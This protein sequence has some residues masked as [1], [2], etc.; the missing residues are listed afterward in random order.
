MKVDEHFVHRIQGYLGEQLGLDDFTVESAEQISGAG[1]SRSV[2]R[3]D[4]TSQGGSHPSSYILL[5]EDAASPVPPNRHAEYAALRALSARDEIKVPRAYCMDDGTGPLAHPFIVTEPLPG[6]TNPRHLMK[7]AYLPHAR[8]IALQGFEVLGA[9]AAI[10]AQAIDLGPSV[11]VPAPSDVQGLAMQ[12]MEQLLRDNDATGMPIT[13]AALRHLHRTLPSAP[14]RLSIVHG[15]YRI[16]NYLFDASGI[17]GV[18]DWEMVHKGDALEDLAWSLL[19]N[20][21]FAARPGMIAGFL[22][23]D[24][25]IEAWERASGLTADRDALDWWILFCHVKAFGIW[26][27]AR[28]MFASGKT[29][30]ILMAMVG[31]D[32]PCKQE[33]FMANLLKEHWA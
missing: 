32:M 18:I 16:G 10:D 33:S 23:R 26:I 24:E 29:G 11:P 28:H 21:E 13:Q 25:A 6:T 14:N 8:R 30:D 22:T 12:R 9:L 3:V 27:T 5:I 7:D 20:W 31:R 15:D 19:P 17:T 1:L 2:V 4:A